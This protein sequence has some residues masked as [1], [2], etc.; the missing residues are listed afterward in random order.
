MT[1]PSPGGETRL[2]LVTILYNSADELPGFL[3]SLHA[4]HGCD[5]L[6]WV[7]DNASPDS[8]VA[9][10]QEAAD[11]RIRLI[12][13][14]RNLGFAKAANQGL[15]QAVAAGGR[16]MVLINNDTDFDPD[17][18][19]RLAEC[20][21]ATGAGVVAPRVMK[22]QAPGE[23]SYA[24]GRFSPGWVFEH[25][26]LEYGPQEQTPK[27]VEFA[28]GCCLGIERQ[29]LEIVGL[30][31]ESYFVYWEDTDFC[32][33]L[34]QRGIPILYLPGP[35][36]RH[37]G[38]ASSEGTFSL[39]YCRLYYRCYMQFLRK[40]FGRKVALRTFLRVAL[41]EGQ[42]PNRLR[43]KLRTMIAAMLAGLVSPLRP[44]PRLDQNTTSRLTS[45]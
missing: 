15:R 33:R 2:H 38:G 35:F 24:G 34:N 42:R 44:E 36:L 25:L 37:D 31:D 28:S 41:R 3:A 23:V 12:R 8:S 29:V 21:D 39:A 5:W 11:P 13:N 30:L 43:G 17:F 9:L 22:R 40:H 1:P 20:W 45:L 10:V 6:L 18:L 4:Q 14:D 16:R 26:P 27:A 19:H 32:M 7:V